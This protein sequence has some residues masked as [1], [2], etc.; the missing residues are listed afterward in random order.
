[1]QVHHLQALKSVL[2]AWDP[3][4]YRVSHRREDKTECCLLLT[5][6]DIIK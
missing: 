4:K 6:D 5:Q 1:M 2:P 3:S